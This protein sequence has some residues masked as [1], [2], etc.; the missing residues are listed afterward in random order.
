MI[1]Q[2]KE[3]DVEKNGYRQTG[4]QTEIQYTN[5]VKSKKLGKKL[6]ATN[7]MNP[8]HNFIN[9]ISYLNCI[10]IV[11]N[12]LFPRITPLNLSSQ[13]K[14]KAVLNSIVLNN[15]IKKH[16]FSFINIKLKNRS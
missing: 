7:L 1:V 15:I 4:S 14:I 12:P 3:E 8:P 16:T 13:K 5:P 11:N 9:I 10:K 6:A 2:C